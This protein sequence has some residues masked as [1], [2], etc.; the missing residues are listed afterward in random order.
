MNIQLPPYDGNISV[1][2][3]HF[4][5]LLILLVSFLFNPKTDELK[6]TSFVSIRCLEWP[7]NIL[8]VTKD[9]LRSIFVPRRRRH[10]SSFVTVEEEVLQERSDE[11]ESNAE[12]IK[13]YL[14]AYLRIYGL[15]FEYTCIPFDCAMVMNARGSKNGRR[16]SLY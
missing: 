14:C 16:V 4:F 10:S 15:S 12:T 1:L 2:Y 8:S 11:I 7:G 13:Y 5:N 3:G 9:E 6:G